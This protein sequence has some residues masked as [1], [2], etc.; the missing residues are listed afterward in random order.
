MPK[1]KKI[2]KT[3]KVKKIKTKIAIKAPEKKSAL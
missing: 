2:K 3:K 1:K